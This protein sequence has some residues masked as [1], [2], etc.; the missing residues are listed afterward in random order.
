MALLRLPLLCLLV[1][2]MTSCAVQP[3]E[4]VSPV[5]LPSA[6]SQPGAAP[7]PD[8][9]WIALE[10]D[11]LAELIE[12]ALDGNFT[13]RSAWDRLDQA[14]A[15]AR[16]REAALVP[17]LDG[18]GSASRTVTDTDQTGRSYTDAFSLGLSASYEVD[19]WGR[20]RATRDAAETDALATEEN[21]RAAAISLSAQ[22]ATAWYQLV[23]QR[24]Q[25]ALVDEQIGTLEDYLELVVLQF[26]R[27]QASGTDVLQQRQL[28]EAKRSEKILTEAQVEV[29][30][31]QIAVLLG[32]APGSVDLADTAA[33][34]DLPPLPDTGLPAEWVRNRPD[35]RSAYL[36]VQ[37][38][39]LRVAAAIAD[40]FPRISLS[41]RA[42]T[43]A[44]EPSD[45]F[46]DWL[47]TLAGNLAA[48]LFDG[49]SRKAEVDRTEAA[50]SQ[51]LNVYTQ[52]M[53]TGLAEV[54][55]ALALERQQKL[56]LSSVS[57]QLTLSKQSLDDIKQQYSKGA[58]D[59]LR[60]LTAQ[61]SHQNLQRN[62]LSARRELVLDR[63]DLYRA[64][65]GGWELRRSCDASE[66]EPHAAEPAAGGV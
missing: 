48:P 31:N 37:A 61:L 52:T 22:V 6:F 36:Q 47:A 25:L 2:L 43:S 62:Y 35:I 33:L 13:L 58:L 64:L 17:S 23:E 24:G 8:N 38:A 1:A 21:L 28:A 9:W 46:S 53:L 14:R 4:V 12:R 50:R 44:T 11:R 15:I 55:D 19:L 56:Y 39:D 42:D 7:A 66:G 40:R 49:G 30:Q 51:A 59:Y 63:I 45:L 65:G 20:V 18:T 29:L 41:G 34:P 3:T 26:R 60:F 32:A 10:D 27:G 5:Q 54:E 57:A 16:Q